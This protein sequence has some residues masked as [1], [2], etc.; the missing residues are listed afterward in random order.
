M[1]E[2]M[3]LCFIG[4]IGWIGAGGFGS[5]FALAL[6][7]YATTAY[8]TQS[9]RFNF[10]ITKKRRYN[11]GHGSEGLRGRFLEGQE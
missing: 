10:K 11:D 3:V 2:R 4:A 5:W 6:V 1:T 9:Y 8:V 7:A